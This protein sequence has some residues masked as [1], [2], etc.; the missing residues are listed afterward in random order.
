[1]SRSALESPATTLTSTPAGSGTPT[2]TK[3]PSATTPAPPDSGELPGELPHG[4]RKLTGVVERAGDC[5]LLRVGPRLWGL[6]GS[7]VQG[8]RAAERVT[9]Q[10]QIT[11]AG[12]GC[13]EAGAARS[14]VVR[15]V[16]RS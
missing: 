3:P 6:T 13:A 5:T 4:D 16:T 8:L 15:R 12:G 2:A 10:G 9:V 11:T 1:V 7:P 14:M